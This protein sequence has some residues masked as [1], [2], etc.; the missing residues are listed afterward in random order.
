MATEF[1]DKS[2]L[3]PNL[4]NTLPYLKPEDVANSIV[5][6]ISTPQHVQITELTIKPFGQL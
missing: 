6:V 1:F 5:H 2:G 4:L 3:D